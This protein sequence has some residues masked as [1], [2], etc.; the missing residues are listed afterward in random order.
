MVGCYLY[1]FGN[2]KQS[3]PETVLYQ[4]NRAKEL[5]VNGLVDGLVLH[6]NGVVGM[7][8]E[9]VEVAKDWMEENGDIAIP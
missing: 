4:L 7:G 1:D 2:K 3:N 6:T 9:A 8:F 5:L